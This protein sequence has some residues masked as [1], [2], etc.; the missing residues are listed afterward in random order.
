[1]LR[2]RHSD[3][4][5]IP[6]A[7]IMYILSHFMKYLT[8]TPALIALLFA[9]TVSAQAYYPSTSYPSYGASYGSACVALARDLSYG[10]RGS[11]VSAL[12]QFLVN[13]N[14]PGGGSWM[15]TGYYGNATVQAVRNF[16]QAAGLPVTGFVD[17]ATR[18]AIQT[19][20]C[21]QGQ[22]VLGNTY[23]YG[24]PYS[25]PTYSYPPYSMPTYPTYPSYPPCTPIGS[26]HGYIL[27]G[28]SSVTKPIIRE[29]EGPSSLPIGVV[30][31]WFVTVSA[32]A[33]SQTVVSVDW[34]D[35]GYYGYGY[36]AGVPLSTYVSGTQT[37]TF[38]HA[39]REQGNYNVEF[40]LKGFGGSD[41][42]SKTVKVTDYASSLLSISS[43]S[44]SSGKTGASITIRGSGFTSSNDVHFGV[45]G[46]RDVSSSGSGTWI[47]FT[48]PEWIS[49]CDLVQPGYYCGSPV[50]PVRPGTYPIFVTNSQ[51]TSNII[52][53]EVTD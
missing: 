17:A 22:G 12:Q 33:G 34:D 13:Q 1:M 35:D 49:A 25:T 50:Q 21:S 42:S 28:G 15:V 46:K 37:L 9:S 8:F 31:T 14:Y 16:Q 32:P 40:E 44:V 7:F 39:Y 43:L 10:S 38:T 52:Y 41:T 26:S 48:I 20:S 4:I 45:G 18:S 30:G 23:S 27:C 19:R 6:V 5:T 51:G 29:I 53:F 47:T 36:G 24:Y 11:E 3:E 2:L